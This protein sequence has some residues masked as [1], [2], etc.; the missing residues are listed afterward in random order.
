MKLWSVL[1]GTV[2]LA[3][4]Q[5][6]PVQLPVVHK[7]LP[8]PEKVVELPRQAPEPVKPVLA[9]SDDA[10]SLTAWAKF[11][12]ELLAMNGKQ[13]DALSKE[14]PPS[15]V[16]NLQQLLIRIHPDTP[17]AV[18]FKAQMQLG[19]Q[20]TILP[21]GLA[22]LLRWDYAYNQKLLESESAVK[23]LGRL[24]GQQQ[25][26]LDRLQKQNADL[27]KKIDALTQIEA[28]LNQNGGG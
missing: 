27:Q 6:G 18:R 5:G 12:S 3:G 7:P 14:L 26:N 4:C 16:S 25:D 11:R 19:E 13:R 24:N 8:A 23:A 22:E 9:I 21:K 28:K 1:A 10:L 17:Y 15:A 20:L 2:L